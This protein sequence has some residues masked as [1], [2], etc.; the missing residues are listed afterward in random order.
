MMYKVGLFTNIQKIVDFLGKD[1]CTILPQFHALTG[2]YFFKVGE[3]K[4]LKKLL[5]NQDNLSLI[6][7][8][9]LNKLLSINDVEECIQ[10]IQAV[11][12]SGL[13]GEDYVK[14]RIQLYK[15]QKKKSLIFLFLSDGLFTFFGGVELF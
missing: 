14:T 15:N 8:L 3:L 6:C 11:V 2:S 10:F 13:V 9:E 4:L 7:N 12:Y 1:L 5:R